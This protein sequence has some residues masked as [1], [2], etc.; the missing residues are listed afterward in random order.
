[1]RVP[2]RLEE[3]RGEELWSPPPAAVQHDRR[4][5]TDDVLRAPFERRPR[6]GRGGHRRPLPPAPARPRRRRRTPR[7]GGDGAAAGSADGRTPALRASRTPD[8]RRGPELPREPPAP[9]PGHVEKRDGSPGDHRSGRGSRLL[10]GSAC[11]DVLVGGLRATVPDDP[12]GRPGGGARAAAGP[13]P[14]GSTRLRLRR[15]PAERPGTSLALRAGPARRRARP[16]DGREPQPRRG[17]TRRRARARR[18]PA[19]S[20]AQPQRGH[21]RRRPG[22]AGCG[23]QTRCG[24]DRGAPVRAVDDGPSGRRG[25]S[26]R[27][28]AAGGVPSGPRRDTD[29]PSAPGAATARARGAHGGGARRHHGPVCRS[30]SGVPA[31]GPFRRCVPASFGETPSEALAR[32]R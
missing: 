12:A 3:K 1:M 29:D 17:P 31:P 22:R 11:G 7:D 19:R 20:A 4:L 27:A 9:R 21:G 25:A 26:Q 32:P 30:G 6:R 18:P 28:G 23:H 2:K 24:P 10:T 15:R 13:L 8:D 5:V 16:P 14:E